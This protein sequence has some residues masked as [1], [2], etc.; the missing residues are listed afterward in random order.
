MCFVIIK[1]IPVDS[2]F[3]ILQGPKNKSLHALGGQE[4]TNIKLVILVFL[5]LLK[6]QNR[7]SVPERIKSVKLIIALLM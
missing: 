2:R 4:N 5:V 1:S 3:R 7:R 6:Y